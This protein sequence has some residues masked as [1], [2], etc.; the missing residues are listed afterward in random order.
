MIYIENKNGTQRVVIPTNDTNVEYVNFVPQEGDSNYYTKTQT[1]EK[2]AQSST[3]VLGEVGDWLSHYPTTD[4][5]HDAIENVTVDLTGYATED[6]VE[7]Q[8]YATTQ[9]VDDVV[10]NIPTGGEGLEVNIESMILGN[11]AID[12]LAFDRLFASYSQGIPSYIFDTDTKAIM[13]VVGAVE[14]PVNGAGIG[15]ILYVLNKDVLIQ[16]KRANLLGIQR[17]LRTDIPLGGSTDLSDYYTKGE[18]DTIEDDL[19]TQITDNHYSIIGLDSRVKDI[20]L[21]GGGSGGDSDVRVYEAL[22]DDATAQ[23]TRFTNQMVYD[24]FNDYSNGL[25]VQVRIGGELFNVYFAESTD[26]F[27]YV[28]ILAGNILGQLKGDINLPS[29]DAIYDEKILVT[30]EIWNQVPYL[31]VTGGAVFNGEVRFNASGFKDIASGIKCAFKTIKSQSVDQWTRFIHAGTDG[32]NIYFVSSDEAGNTQLAMIDTEGNIY[33]GKDKLSDK[34]A[35]KTYV[36]EVLPHKYDY[37]ITDDIALTG[38]FTEGEGYELFNDVRD[39]ADVNFKLIMFDGQAKLI[40]FQIIYDR[41]MDNVNFMFLDYG[42]YIMCTLESNGD[43]SISTA[44]FN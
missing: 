36:D 23:Y 37:T 43:V 30:D 39:G 35:T 2:I 29:E 12:G 40:P 25:R 17:A 9:Y 31:T 16:Y 18:V 4:Q 34:Y 44:N 24:M 27:Y 3:A 21:N 6:W 11:S 28:N 26:P 38:S 1:D 42:R 32:E 22:W 10:A 19:Q 15:S 8:G 20:E 33:E 7:E 5:M 41:N 13:P 14:D